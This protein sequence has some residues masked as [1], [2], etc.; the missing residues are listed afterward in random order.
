MT[1]RRMRVFLSRT[2]PPLWRVY[3]PCCDEGWHTMYV[4]VYDVAGRHARLRHGAV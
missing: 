1:A 2:M 3:C 4:F